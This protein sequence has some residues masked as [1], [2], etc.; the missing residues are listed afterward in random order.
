MGAGHAAARR[1]DRRRTDPSAGPATGYFPGGSWEYRR[2]LEVTGPTGADRRVVL[3]F[4]GVYRDAVVSVNGTI[5]AH[6]PYGYSNFFV[7]IDH[8]LR[9]DAENELRVEVRGRRRLPLVLGR[10]H[11]PERVA[12]AVGAVSTSRPTGSQVRTPEIDDA[13]AVVAVAADVRNRVAAPR[14][15][16]PSASSC[17]DADGAVVARD[18]R[19]G[20]D[21]PGR[22][23]HRAAPAARCRPRRWSP[24]DPYLYTCRAD[25]ARRRRRRRRGVDDVRHPVARASIAERGC[26]STA[27][28]SSSA[29][30]ACTTTTACSAP[31]PSTAPTSAGSSCCT[32]RA[33]TRIRSAHNPMSK[34][35]LAAC[36]RLGML[37]MDE[38]FDMWTQ[39]KTDDDY[40]L[41]FADW[42]EADVEAMVRKDVNHPSVILYSI[43]NEVPDG[44][45]PAGL[46]LGRAL[47]EKVRALDDTR[48]VTQ[49]VTGLLVG[50]PELFDEIRDAATATGTDEDTGVNTA[51]MNLAD[52]MAHAMRSPVV[53]DKTS[54]GVLA[55]RRRRVQLHGD[56]LRA[57]PRAVPATGDRRDRV[58]PADG[59]HGLGRRARQPQRHRRLHLD[60]LGLPRRGRHRPHRVRRATERARHVG[61]PRRLPV[62]HRLVRRHRHHRPP[63]PAVVL[64]RDRLRSPHRSVP[65]G[66]AARAPRQDGR[67]FEPV[68]VE[69]RRVE[70][71]LGRPRG[72]AGRGRGLRR[73]RRG[74]AAR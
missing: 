3:E 12:P 20:D 21:V 64:P 30:P 58:P 56:P 22:H 8:L 50:G 37:V 17:V 47:A 68:G 35:M 31:P 48:F 40:A 7:P 41:R 45:T 63:P 42:W 65:R 32:P 72:R 11:L 26:G 25:A 14:R 62:A 60:R 29:A 61:V 16:R 27:S 69:R 28:R 55:P 70:L 49:A 15:G 71:E 18:R 59:R 2:T 57:R 51:T 46:H 9:H 44:S 6:R 19:A 1:H 13:G 73:R 24:D 33:S 4:E 34:A 39:T 74:G 23:H 10:R 5:A 54:R 52:F 38:T 36:D 66:A 43:G 67:A 53:A